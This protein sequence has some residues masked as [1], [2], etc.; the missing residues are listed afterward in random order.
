MWIRLYARACVPMYIYVH[1]ND[2]DWLINPIIDV[3]VSTIATKSSVLNKW[4]IKQL[5]VQMMH[6]IIIIQ[7]KDTEFKVLNQ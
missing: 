6:F 1:M 7:F 3:I 5:C 2:V 4:Q